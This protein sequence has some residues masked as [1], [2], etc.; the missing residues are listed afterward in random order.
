M[1][2]SYPKDVLVDAD[3]LV[4]LAKKNDTNH[5][6][7]V[8][9][10]LQLQKFGATFYLSPFTVAEAATVLSYKATHEAAKRFLRETRKLDLPVLVLTEKDQHLADK[11]FLKQKGKG[12]SYFDC[13]NMALLERYSKQLAGIFSFDK[14]YSRNGFKLAEKMV[15]GY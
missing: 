10:N 5:A 3:A 4:A 15:S 14:V 9:I 12:N 6:Q 11:W 7:A 13:Y 1:A 8:K 2:P